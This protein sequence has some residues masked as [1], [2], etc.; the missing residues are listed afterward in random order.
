MDGEKVARDHI[1]SMGGCETK[2]LVEKEMKR[3]QSW[4]IQAQYDFDQKPGNEEGGKRAEVMGI[5]IVLVAVNSGMWILVSLV[6]CV[7]NIIQ[8]NSSLCVR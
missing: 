7:A 8:V 3:D 5:A 1:S 6:A 4:V 2:E